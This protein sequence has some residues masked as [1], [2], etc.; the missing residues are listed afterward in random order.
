MVD[1]KTNEYYAVILSALLHDIGIFVQR[2]KKEPSPNHL[3]LGKE[4]VESNLSK[5][6]ASIVSKEDYKTL[7]SGI[8][9][10]HEDDGYI[11]LA[12]S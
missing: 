6:L 4:W 11:S 10:H 7:L 1:F 8:S 9:R 2:S 5:K 12:D 3:L